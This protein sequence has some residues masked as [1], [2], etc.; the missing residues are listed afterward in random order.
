M[1]ALTLFTPGSAIPK[2]TEMHLPSKTTEKPT[3]NERR[4]SLPAAVI[5]KGQH[6][7][8][9]AGHTSEVLLTQSLDTETSENATVAMNTPATREADEAWSG[10][11]SSLRAS[12]S[13]ANTTPIIRKQPNEARSDNGA[14]TS[15]ALA[16]TTSAATRPANEARPDIQS[17]TNTSNTRSFAS[18][19]IQSRYPLYTCAHWAR[20]LECYFGRDCAYEH[21]HTGVVSSSIPRREITCAFW[22]KG[23]C[24]KSADQCKFVHAETRYIAGNPGQPPARLSPDDILE[25]VRKETRPGNPLVEDAVY[26]NQSGQDALSKPD[27]EQGAIPT[28]KWELTCWFWLFQTPPCRNRGRDCLWSHTE[29]EYVAP[30][31]K[32]E[33]PILYKHALEQIYGGSSSNTRSQ[34]PMLDGAREYDD[35]PLS[36]LQASSPPRSARVRQDTDGN[37]IGR[38]VLPDLSVRRGTQTFGGANSKVSKVVSSLSCHMTRFTSQFQFQIS[39]STSILATFKQTSQFFPMISCFMSSAHRNPIGRC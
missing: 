20:G 14:L 5:R 1:S 32:G 18:A 22:A 34:L 35:E 26:I 36:M 6:M 30:K 7:S 21:Y 13:G 25:S 4:V 16:T 24:R 31:H 8:K 27:Q 23:K 2:S 9:A 39:L 12:A 3:T 28:K 10:M 29:Q 33:T 17:P 38:T 37:N 19:S 15:S 11:V